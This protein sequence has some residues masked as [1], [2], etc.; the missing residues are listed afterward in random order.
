[1][2]ASSY[3]TPGVYIEW[4]DVN[5]QYLDVGRSDVAGFIGIAERGPIH[6]ATK[7]ESARQFSST[8][9]GT[10][11]QGYLAYA[12]N[13]FFDNG[14]RTCWVVRVADPASAACA[15]VRVKVAAAA[16][17]VLAAVNEGAWGNGITI[18]PVLDNGN[19]TGVLAKTPDGLSQTILVADLTTSF[20]PNTP[21]T[22]NNLLGIADRLLPDVQAPTVIQVEADN[23]ALPLM[24]IG[25]STATLLLSGGADGLKA[26]TPDHFAGDSNGINRWGMD[27]LARVD[28]VSFVSVPDLVYRA[29]PIGP[30]VD[31][32]GFPD[33]DAHRILAA[34]TRIVTSCMATH[35]RIVLLDPPFGGRDAVLHYRPGLP[36]SNFA[37]LYYPWIMVTDPLGVPGSVRTIPPSGY[38]AGMV[39]RV[40]RLRGV[41]K[42]PANEVLEG[43]WDVVDDID[44]ATHGVLNDLAINAI[45]VIPG[46]DTLVLGAR[47]LDPGIR[48]R[49]VN[50][51]RLFAM[52]ES[53]LKQQMQWVTFEPNNPRLWKEID[54][55]VR[56]FLERLYRAGMLDGASSDDAYFVRCDD[57][58]NPPNET[59]DGR[60]TC[61]IGIQP[62]FPAEFVVVRV[63]VTRSGIEVEEKGSQ[64][65]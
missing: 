50:V 65:A 17:I 52:I 63:G 59:D 43:A 34:Q 38:V 2:A 42:P 36:P 10:I 11:L 47:T 13:G 58:T 53:S 32:I 56:G 9:G 29:D 46:R 35:D 12:V 21:A 30:P 19:I 57:S 8:Y 31:F 15:R 28:G 5:P 37:A 39:A 6:V 61:L 41:A 4:Q 62:P 3:R 14:G 45:R 54:R 64:D 55:V 25:P 24:P 22:V 44:P 20:A 1:M 51:R 33:P 26:L 16:P 27:A 18:E 23:S 60:A 40:D 48:W 7:I 49:Y